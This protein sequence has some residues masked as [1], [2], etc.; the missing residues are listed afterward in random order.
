MQIAAKKHQLYNMNFSYKDGIL[1]ALI[2]EVYPRTPIFPDLNLSQLLN[3]PDIKMSIFLEH[4]TFAREVEQNFQRDL[5]FGNDKLVNISAQSNPTE[6][7][8]LQKVQTSKV[9]S[10]VFKEIFEEYVTAIMEAAPL[11]EIGPS[12]LPEIEHSFQKILDDVKTIPSDSIQ[13]RVTHSRFLNQH[14]YFRVIDNDPKSVNGD[15]KVRLR[16]TINPEVTFSIDKCTFRSD[17][18]D[19]WVD[20]LNEYFADIFGKRETQNRISLKDRF[21]KCLAA[22]CSRCNETFEGPLWIVKLKDHIGR[23]H[24]VDKPWRCVKC[25]GKWDQFE[26]LQME[27]KHECKEPR[28]A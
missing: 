18:P 13:T 1:S 28:N 24:F 11:Y 23:H 14:K 21:K 15:L 3:W 19:V 25:K 17:Q 10:M 20:A 7:R 5:I 2:P 9:N 6:T 27:W 22:K 26:L 4:L 8:Y 16:E 12:K